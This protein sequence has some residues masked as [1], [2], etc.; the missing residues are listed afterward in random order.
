MNNTFTNSSSWGSVIDPQA[1]QQDSDLIFSTEMAQNFGDY[2]PVLVG[3][4]SSNWRVGC[5]AVGPRPTTVRAPDD[6]PTNR[7]QAVV[8]PM[9]S[10][11]PPSPEVD[12][13]G[14]ELDYGVDYSNVSRNLII[15][16]LPSD[17]TDVHLI[18]LFVRFGGLHSVKIMRNP[19]VS[20]QI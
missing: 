2:E 13:V 4:A 20:N 9:M 11:P 16:Y 14:P 10:M 1:Y 17:F 8:R 19:T 12:P 5:Q 6:V 15:N 7:Q 3:P 18:D